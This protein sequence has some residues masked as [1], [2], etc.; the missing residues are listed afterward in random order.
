MSFS[1][2]LADAF[3]TVFDSTPYTALDPIVKVNNMHRGS[4][5]I[6]GDHSATKSSENRNLIYIG[7]IYE[8]SAGK[9]YFGADAWVDVSFPHV[10]YVTGARGSGK[11]FDLGVLIEGLAKLKNPSNVGHDVDPVA[12]VLID[13]QSQF[14]TRRFEPY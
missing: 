13:M 4:N 6:F 12:T 11:S 8:A 1:T 5:L 10:I 7:K 3:G 2:K 9:N 14:W